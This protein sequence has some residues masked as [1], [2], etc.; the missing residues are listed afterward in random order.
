DGPFIDFASTAPAFRSPVALR[1]P[2]FG[3]LHAWTVS[4]TRRG[5]S[6][7]RDRRN[8]AALPPQPVGQAPAVA[9]ARAPLATTRARSGGRGC[10]SRRRPPLGPARTRA[11][12]PRDVLLRR[13]HGRREPA[14]CD[15]GGR[16]ERRR[17][18]HGA[19]TGR[20]DQGCEGRARSPLAG[21]TPATLARG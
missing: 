12:R 15:A 18:R 20:A 6:R 21:P 9:P 10:D 3:R 13:S 14:L 8:P 16:P 11:R 4:R 2:S 19:R 1:S 5:R 17:R 7:R